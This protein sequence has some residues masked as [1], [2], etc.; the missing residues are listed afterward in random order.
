[1]EHATF[2]GDHAVLYQRNKRNVCKNPIKYSHVDPISFLDKLSQCDLPNEDI[3]LEPIV[4]NLSETLYECAAD[5]RTSNQ[6]PQADLTLSRW[7]RLL[8]G[9]CD[10]QVWGHGLILKAG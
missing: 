7:E 10:E 4:M 1:M 8:E 5:S 6:A 3:E 9:S 2:L